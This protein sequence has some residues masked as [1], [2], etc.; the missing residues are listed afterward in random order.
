MGVGGHCMTSQRRYEVELEVA[1]P[2][3]MFTRPDTGAVPVS[4]PAP[5]SSAARG[6]F[7][8]I[9]RFRSAWIRPTSVAICGPIRYA[10]YTTNYGGP[11]RK[12][13]QLLKGASYQLI[14]TVLVDVC[15]QLRGVVEELSAPPVGVATTNHLHFLQHRFRKRVVRG[16]SFRSVCL[17]WSEFLATYVG[18][19]RPGTRPVESIDLDVAS[20]LFSV[21]E[22][23][24][25]GAYNPA[26]RQNVRI[27]H[28]VLPYA[29]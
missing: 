7:E 23:P 25:G 18:P 28:G 2:M 5:T 8:A 12:A 29:E 11:L 15:Y 13:D 4:Y 16:Q 19:F 14:A 26:F 3:A 6:M 20:M 17:G 9:A 21:F 1:G 22:G 24:D 27:T 10:Q